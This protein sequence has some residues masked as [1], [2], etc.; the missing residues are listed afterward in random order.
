[1][2]ALCGRTQRVDEYPIPDP[3][4]VRSVA[5]RSVLSQ[6]SGLTSL[7]EVAADVA[8]HC[9][10]PV[11]P[12][13]VVEALNDR[14]GGL[15]VVENWVYSRGTERA[16]ANPVRASRGMLAVA[17]VLTATELHRGWC[18][19]LRAHG[20]VHEPPVE[21][22]VAVLRADGAFVVED[23]PGAGRAT[24]RLRTPLSP[25]QV[26]GRSAL[27]LI[28]AISTAPGGVASRA[29]LNRAG[30]DAGLSTATVSAYLTQHE[31]FVHYA[32]TLWTVVG[33][34]VDPGLAEAGRSAG[35]RPV[36]AA[37]RRLAGS[38]EVQRPVR[39]LATT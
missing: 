2:A 31:A 32:P 35:G 11:R 19:R 23:Q 28:D 5:R 36:P 13:V 10:R 20:I 33:I 26:Y 6:G 30:T 37:I 29:E 38:H 7:S 8:R 15:A 21:A 3:A 1:V 34:E 9:A 18:R 17:G 14:T 24:V 27:V 22:L 16:N 12:A 25:R 39:R 4:V